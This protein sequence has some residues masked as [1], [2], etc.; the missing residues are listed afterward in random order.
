MALKSIGPDVF[1]SILAQNGRSAPPRLGT[2]Q[3]LAAYN[4]MPWIRAVVQKVS[5]SVA[6]NPY[7]LYAAQRG[8]KAIRND[9]LAKTTDGRARHA[10]ITRGLKTGELREITN[11]AFLD[12]MSIGTPPFFDGTVAAQLTQVHTDLVGESMWVL[13]R[14]AIGGKGGRGTPLSYWVIPPSWVESVPTI[15]NPMFRVVG[16]Y[17][18]RE[19]H[20]DDVVWNYHPNPADPYQRGTGYGHVLGDELETDEYAAKYMKSFFYNDARPPFLV[21]IE[22]ADGSEVERVRSWWNTKHQGFGRW[23]KPG[24]INRKVDVHEFGHS[25]KDMGMRELREFE[26]NCIMQVYGFPPEIFGITESS[27][28]ATSEAAKSIYAEHVV[29]P[30][31]EVER[32]RRQRIVE[33]E[34]DDRLIVGYTSPIPE[35]KEHQ[36]KV[37][38]AI[39]YAFEMDEVRVAGGLEEKEDG[40]G[41]VHM[42]PFTVTPRLRLDE[43][44]EPEPIVEPTQAEAAERALLRAYRTKAGEEDVISVVLS[45]RPESLITRS[46]PA[47]SKTVETFGQ[48]TMDEATAGITFNMRS[49]EVETFLQRWGLDRI[50]KKVNETTIDQLRNSLRD[51]VKLGESTADLMDRIENIFTH[52]STVRAKMIA[53]TETARASNFGATKGMKQAGIKQKEWLATQD[54]AV[55]DTHSAMD[56][57]VVGIDETFVSPSGAHAMH[58]GDFGVAEEDINC[59]CGVLSKFPESSRS[60]ERVARWKAVEA[61]RVPFER[62]LQRALKQGFAEQRADALRALALSSGEAA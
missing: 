3:L 61:D 12:F 60:A 24:F 2:R 21:S 47:I 5:F 45:I 33:S 8:S 19:I 35:D 58:P 22:G 4:T 27:N 10:L 15:N 6:T 56:T 29:T 41:K 34:F 48:K 36:L 57:Q 42:V 1:G 32:S 39:P 18:A 54:D 28:R 59:R 26:R 31:L 14:K 49:P 16:P 17:G 13:E 23:W 52:A 46:K 7:Q 11:N 20:A 9:I 50:T 44:P 53:R 30:R 55:R 62:Q 43:E 37:M 38:T 25:M 51:G 40:S